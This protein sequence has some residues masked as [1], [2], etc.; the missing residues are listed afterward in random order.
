MRN[1][2]KRRRGGFTL[3][4]VLLV[5]VILVVLGSLAVTAYLPIQKRANVNAAKAQIGA[6]KT[7]LGTFSLDMG[8]R[9]PTT[10]EGLDS[11]CNAPSDASDR[12]NGPYIEGGQFP[13]DP[14]GQ[15]YQ[16]QLNDDGNS[17][18][19]WSFGPNMMDGDDDDVGNWTDRDTR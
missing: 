3:V 17:Y 6:F 16:Y 11:L 8:G 18:T 2:R 13:L 10:E 4:E 14:W 9:Y 5:L 15:E 12:W 7:P 1:H 19:A